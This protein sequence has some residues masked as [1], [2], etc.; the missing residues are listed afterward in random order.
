MNYPGSNVRR[1][2]RQCRHAPVD[3]DDAP[4]TV[5]NPARWWHLAI[6]APEDLCRSW[7]AEETGSNMHDGAKN[8]NDSISQALVSNVEFKF[9]F[10]FSPQR[11]IGKELTDKHKSEMR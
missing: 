2:R 3:G 5:V 8:E 9:S 11:S 4:P 6:C 1:H 7:R 10:F